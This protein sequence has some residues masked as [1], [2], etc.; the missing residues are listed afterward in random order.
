[1][2]LKQLEVFVAVAETGS[3]SKGAEAAFITQSTVSQHIGALESEFG[4]KLLDRTGRGALPT[5]GGKVLLRHARQLLNGAR[6]TGEAMARFRGLDDATLSI[7]GSNIPGNYLIPA[8][9]PK[10]L[11]RFPGL[12]LT[13][14]QGD[15]RDILTRI[16]RQEVEVGIVGSRFGEEGCT[17][18]PICRDDIRLVVGQ[19][20]PW[21]GRKVVRLQEL[22]GVEI[23]LRESG[24]GTGDTVLEA[25]LKAGLS[26]Q[27]L[28][29]RAWLGSNEAVKHA[30]AASVG[31]SFL[32]LISVQK[33]VERG[34][35]IP[36]AVEGLEISREFYLASRTGREL[37]PA[38]SAFA[39]VM[40]EVGKGT[41]EPPGVPV[42]PL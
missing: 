25:L 21:H 2:N 42:T 10:L 15:S 28:T 38:A 6:E 11:K 17:F 20:H 19:G 1:M 41:A 14:L 30:V 24:S 26:L 5:E 4:I 27:D 29:V 37:S 23:I 8:A 22:Q 32:S 12:K 7:G 36:I 9:L 40:L 39:G 31:V 3:F 18:T 16:V 13:L 34:E 35:I 33:E